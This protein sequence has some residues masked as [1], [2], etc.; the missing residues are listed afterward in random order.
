M[1]KPASRTISTFRY[2][3]D[4]YIVERVKNDEPNTT[5]NSLLQNTIEASGRT[6]E[7]IEQFR[8]SP[9]KAVGPYL[10]V[11]MIMVRYDR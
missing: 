7:V 8:P 1:V 3:Q 10:A 5:R 9:D 4:Y 6:S 2:D 11:G